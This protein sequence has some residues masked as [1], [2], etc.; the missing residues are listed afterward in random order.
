MLE[1]AKALTFFASLLSLY[2]TALTAFFIP[3]TRWED[4]LYLAVAKLAITAFICCF[5]GLIFRWPSRTNPDAN[6]PLAATLPV[7]LFLWGAAA[8]TLL[9]LTSWYLS[10]GA[11][12]F[13]NH[14]PACS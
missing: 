14:Y 9:F 1:L 12:T 11:P 4:R 2:W 3:G 8:I 10:C 6:Q 7:R 13:G 5:S